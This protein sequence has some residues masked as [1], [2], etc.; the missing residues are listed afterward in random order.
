[1]EFPSSDF[2][3]TNNVVFVDTT[4][5][6][7][8]ACLVQ[9]G[10]VTSAISKQGGALENL[11]VILK[12]IFDSAKISISEISAFGFCQ[13]VGSILGIRTASATLSTFRAVN[14]KSICFTWDLLEVYSQILKDENSEFALICPSRKNFANICT[15]KNGEFSA[16]EIPSSEIQ[17]IAL[18]KYFIEQ[19]KSL[20]KNF[21]HLKR[22]SFD[23]EK[24]ANFLMQNQNF[25]RAIASSEILDATLLAKREYVKWNLTAHS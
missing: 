2:L 8:S 24:I 21:E 1:M 20:D 10:R 18:P 5:D 11:F 14:Q 19:R 15:F 7:I 9:G 4:A 12:E 6:C 17:N 3:S 23:A 16:Q 13:G 22:V 25:A